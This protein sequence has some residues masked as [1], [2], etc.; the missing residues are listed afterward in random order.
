MNRTNE[1]DLAAAPSRTELRYG[2]I[3][4]MDGVLV[5][6]YQPHLE[7]WQLTAREYHLDITEP[8]FAHSFGCTSRE[9]IH[10]L[11]GDTFTDDQ[12]RQFDQRKEVIYRELIRKNIPAVAGLHG[13]LKSLADDGA[14]IAVGSSGPIENVNLVLDTLGIRNYF[15]AIVSAHDVRAG[16]PNPEVFLKAAQKLCLS[17]GQCLVIEDAP[18]GIQAAHAAGM[19]C[20]ALTTSHPPDRIAAADT[21]VKDLGHITLDKV[22]SLTH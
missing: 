18:P 13:L 20:I 8:Q 9:I 11:W 10:S 6:S 22:R 14:K 16:K 19:K 17:P 21:I 12:I 15:S 7:S 1:P 4:D 5:D 3:F 2:V